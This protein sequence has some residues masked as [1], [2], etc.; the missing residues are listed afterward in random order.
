MLLKKMLAPSCQCKQTF[1]SHF[2]AAMNMKPFANTNPTWK[3]GA[4]HLHSQATAKLAMKRIIVKLY[5]NH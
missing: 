3:S 1:P 5:T 4:G 2:T